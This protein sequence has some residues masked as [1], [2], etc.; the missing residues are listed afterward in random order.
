MKKIFTKLIIILTSIFLISS[1]NVFNKEVFE[2][3]EIN[4][5][6][7]GKAFI[8]VDS[9]LDKKN[10]KNFLNWMLTA[11]TFLTPKNWKKFF[12]EAGYKGDYY[13]TILKNNK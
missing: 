10:L 7:K 8:Q 2:I 12:I 13:L 3:K 5:V 6:S 11:K 1:C 9:Y 4:R